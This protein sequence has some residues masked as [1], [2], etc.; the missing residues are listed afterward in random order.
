VHPC[1]PH[2]I[3]AH[4]AHTA[5]PLARAQPQPCAYHAGPCTCLAI[6]PKEEVFHLSFLRNRLGRGSRLRAT[7]LQGGPRW[8]GDAA[9]CCIAIDPCCYHPCCHR[10]P[11]TYRLHQVVSQPARLQATP[12]P[13]ARAS[14][15]LR[16]PN[17]HPAPAQTLI[18]HP[19]KVVDDNSEARKFSSEEL[20]QLFRPNFATFSSMHDSMGCTCCESAFAPPSHRRQLDLQQAP[21]AGNP[22]N[23]DCPNPQISTPCDPIRRITAL[24]LL[25]AIIAAVAE[26]SSVLPE[27]GS[28]TSVDENG[29][30]HL[31][32]G[33]HELLAKD[34]C[35]GCVQR[36]VSLVFVRTTDLTS[37]A[38]PPARCEEVEEDEMGV[39]DDAD[40]TDDVD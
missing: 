24:T 37:Q 19:H 6:R 23:P 33:S 22:D 8:P 26:P 38:P 1:Q 30:L 35:L 13:P 31:K 5:A 34:E 40:E 16:Q 36:H 7:T 27:H 29:F 17:S 10:S 15:R 14:F 25:R 21:L 20:R 9:P 18:P 28:T 2:L 32:P 12:L 11:V 3:S 4:P 39:S